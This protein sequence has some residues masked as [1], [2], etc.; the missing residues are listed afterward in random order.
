M[1]PHIL[2]AYLPSDLL[3]PMLDGRHR[4]FARL[5]AVLCVGA[6]GKHPL[7]EARQSAQPR[8]E[9]GRQGDGM[10]YT[11]LGRGLVPERPVQ[12]KRPPLH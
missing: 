10:R 6:G 8:H 7:G 11:G 5:H 3:L 9:L 2:E 4:P 1:N 12:I